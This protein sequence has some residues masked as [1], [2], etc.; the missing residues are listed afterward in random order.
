MG[1]TELRWG[2]ASWG[3]SGREVSKVTKGEGIVRDD[4]RITSLFS[5]S[6]KVL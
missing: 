1:E 2:E 3:K 6:A 5:A 4:T